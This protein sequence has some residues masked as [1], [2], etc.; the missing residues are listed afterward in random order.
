MGDRP[1]T[2]VVNIASG[3]GQN[4]VANLAAYG[5]AKAAVML[6]TEACAKE[7]A[8]RGIRV[9]AIA[10]GYIQSEK[11]SAK[12]FTEAESQ[13]LRAGATAGQLLKRVGMAAD[14]ASVV[15]FLCSE[16]ARHMTGQVL[17]VNGGSR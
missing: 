1:D 8:P 11:R 10:P 5:A 17:S 15:A 4:A 12:V 9:N 14:V 7:L 6:F 3:A 2:A 16:D 13:A